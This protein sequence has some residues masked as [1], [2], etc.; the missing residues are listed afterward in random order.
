L[1]QVDKST[2]VDFFMTTW[3]GEKNLEFSGLRTVTRVRFLSRPQA[4]WQLGRTRSSKQPSISS[5]ASRSEL[6]SW[7]RPAGTPPAAALTLTSFSFAAPAGGGNGNANFLPRKE[8]PM[9]K[10]L[11]P[12]PTASPK[13]DPFVPAA[14]RTKQL[15]ELFRQFDLDD[16]GAIGADELMM[17]GQ[18]RRTTGQKVGTWSKEMNQRMVTRMTKDKGASGDI[19]LE[20]RPTPHAPSCSCCGRQITQI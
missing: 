1:I 10:D 19:I 8:V 13:Q 4:A 6:G 5:A 9:P 3:H 14:V 11:G 7:V 12:D 18:M 2:F 15:Q 20:A 16:G 17:L